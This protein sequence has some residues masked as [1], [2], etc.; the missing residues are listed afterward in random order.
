VKPVSS[1]CSTDPAVVR[2]IDSYRALEEFGR[3]RLSANF[4][5]REFLHSEIA[6]YYRLLNVPVDP[7]LAIEA[8]ARLCAELLEPLQAAFGR[9]VIRS[10]YRSPQ[11]N[12]LG[13]VKR[14][15]CA[16]APSRPWCAN[17]RRRMDGLD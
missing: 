9:I 1:D 3:V 11:V 17:A 6:Q 7:D 12:A 5:M 14:L 13:Y 2:R 15:W 16:S 10:G 8:G 4:F